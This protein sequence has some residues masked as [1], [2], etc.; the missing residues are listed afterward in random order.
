MEWRY[1]HSSATIPPAM[2]E[3]LAHWCTLTGAERD[4]G[5]LVHGEKE[6]QQRKNGRVVGWSVMSQLLQ[7]QSA[8]GEV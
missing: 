7:A 6:K 3:G 8:S 1:D 5:Y 4:A 2:F